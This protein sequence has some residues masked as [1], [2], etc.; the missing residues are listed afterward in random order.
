MLDPRYQKLAHVIVHHACRV[1]T[2]DNVL[3]EAFDMPDEFVVVL[4]REISAAGGNAVCTTKHNRVL[5]ELMRQGSEEQAELWGEVERHQMERMQCYVGLR[6]THNSTELADVPPE[7]H[8]HYSK[9]VQHQVHL[10]LRVKKTRWVVLRWPTPSM[11]QQ[12]QMSTEAFEDF[13][14]DTCTVDYPQMAADMAPLQALM[15]DT[16]RVRIVGPGT[17]LRFSIA[18]IPTVGC[19]GERNIPDGEMF[20]APVRDSVEGTLQVNTPSLYR[21]RGMVFDNVRLEFEGGRVT[22]A[23]ANH[24]DAI[25]EI[26]DTDDGARYIGEFSLGFNPKI[27][28]PMLD[29]L[30]DEKI[31]GSFHFTPG[32]AYEEADNGNRSR[33]HWDLVTIQRPEYGGGEIY[34]DDRLVRKDGIFVLDELAALNP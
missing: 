25:E 3:V 32:Q 8:A 21:D 2:G 12:A 20:T 6:G 18:G 19:S 33:I 15:D 4:I 1:G 16:D 30:F 23:D 5:R 11:A 17:D 27:T 28:T 10:E 26:L 13:Y 9:H 22:A 34:F 24:R 31:A 29:T 7:Q 14:F